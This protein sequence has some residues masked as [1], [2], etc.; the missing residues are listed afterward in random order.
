VEQ[1]QLWPIAGVATARSISAHPADGDHID[2][3]KGKQPVLERVIDSLLDLCSPQHHPKE[4]R[5]AMQRA[6]KTAS[7]L[8][9]ANVSS[10]RLDIGTSRTHPQ[11][12][13]PTR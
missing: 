8:I 2:D 10:P 1:S 6:P 7:P 11:A 9:M 5:A 12:A 4:I 3:D 13:I